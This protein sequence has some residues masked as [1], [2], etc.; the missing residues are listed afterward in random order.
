MIDGP[1][2]R[3]LLAAG[4]AGADEAQ[5]LRG[6]LLVAPA[7]VDVVRVARVDDDVV[8]VEQR[9]EVGD[10]AVHGRARLDHDD[11]PPRALERLDEL[12]ERLASR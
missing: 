4:H 2:K 9:H 6:G 5:P 12:L 1:F 3:A 11:D 8:L 7:G 10:H